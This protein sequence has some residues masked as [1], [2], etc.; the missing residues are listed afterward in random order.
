MNEYTDFAELYDELMD[1]VPYEE[2]AEHAVSILRAN[3]VGA[4]DTVAD[5]GCGTGT[6]TLLLAKSG[7]HMIGA[8]ISEEMLSAAERKAEQT[9]PACDDAA[10]APLFI[11]QDMRAL[12]FSGIPV[13]AF[14]SFCDSVNYLLSPEELRQLFHGVSEF[15][16]PGGVFLFDFKTIHLFRDVIG[17]Q[18]IAESREDCAFIWENEYEEESNIN[19]YDLT[20]FRQTDAEGRMFERSFETHEERGYTLG[21]IQS[22]AESAGLYLRQAWNADTYEKICLENSAGAGESDPE[23]I[24]VLLY[25]FL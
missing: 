1:N 22:A 7:F 14:A 20:L 18:T 4:G 23:R 6:M 3:G 5:L 16:L 9:I 25:K 8:D 13:C 19:T 12:D 17:E 24:A 21:E 10:H 2:W 15:L 11:R